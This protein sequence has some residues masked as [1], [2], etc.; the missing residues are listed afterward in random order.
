MTP[1]PKAHT[2]NSWRAKAHLS[3]KPYYRTPPQLNPQHTPNSRR[4]SS[5]FCQER[6]CRRA[7]RP[8]SYNAKLK[9]LFCL[10][11]FEFID[12]SN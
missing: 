2:P 9:N 7:I 5:S 10:A 8:G 4:H 6:L 3:G 1:E 11:H 12:S